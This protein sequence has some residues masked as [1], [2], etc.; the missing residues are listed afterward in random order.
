V[1]KAILKK[2]NFVLDVESAD[3][4]PADVDLVFSWGQNDYR[5]TQYIHRSGTMLAQITPNGEF[6]LLP[7]RLYNDRLSAF[8]L[9][10]MEPLPTMHDRRGANIRHPTSSA[11]GGI[12][13]PT[14]SP[15]VR[16]V[17]DNSL[18]EGG[19]GGTGRNKTLTAEEIKTEVEEFCLNE[20]ALQ[21]FYRELMANST[22]GSSGSGSSSSRPRPSPSPSPSLAASPDQLVPSLRLPSRGQTQQPSQTGMREVSPSRSSSATTISTITS[23]LG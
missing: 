12:A 9:E 18:A 4:F 15:L 7:N 5:Y 10:R 22:A 19:S 14:A 21:A 8:K 2:L 3:S 20:R 6:I 17:P 23:R 16:P 11:S 13:S 1:H